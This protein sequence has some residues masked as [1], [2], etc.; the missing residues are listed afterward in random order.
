MVVLY[1]SMW[2]SFWTRSMVALFGTMTRNQYAALNFC[3][4]AAVT[5]LAMRPVWSL[6]RFVLWV[7]TTAIWLVVCRANS[8]GSL[9]YYSG[10]IAIGA[11]LW[12]TA[13]PRSGYWMRMGGVGSAFLEVPRQL[14]LSLSAPGLLSVQNFKPEGGASA[15]AQI[16]LASVQID[17]RE[18]QAM[19]T[20]RD[21]R[22]HTVTGTAYSNDGQIIP[23]SGTGYT[24]HGFKSAVLPTGNMTVTLTGQN[25]SGQ[26]EK[27]QIY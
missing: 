13:S 24:D 6:K 3:V 1:I 19:Q 12:L 15:S 18:E 17:L 14:Y 5:A 26:T 7:I 11:A 4:V 21:V 22:A 20:W 10:A 27:V 23:L 8:M 16:T 2:Q 25:P 9:A